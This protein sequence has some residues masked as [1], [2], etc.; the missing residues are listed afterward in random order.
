MKQIVA[1]LLVAGSFSVAFGQ[2]GGDAPT[3]IEGNEEALLSAELIGAVNAGTLTMGSDAA[4]GGATAAD[5]APIALESAFT[6]AATLGDGYVSTFVSTAGDEPVFVGMVF[7]G[8]MLAGLPRGVSDGRYDIT[9]AAGYAVWSCCGHEIVVELPELATRTTAFEHFVLNWNPAGHVPDG[10]YRAP[11][12]DLHFYTVTNEER[13]DIASPSAEAMCEVPGPDGQP[14]RAPLD[15]PS[16]E[17]AMTPLPA[18]MMPPGYAF[19]GAVEPGMGNHLVDLGAPEFTPEG[20][21]KT[22]IYGTNGGA[23]TFWEPMITLDYFESQPSEC[24]EISLPQAAPEAG[25]YPSRYCVRYLGDLD[26]YAVTL[27]GFGYLPQSAS[28]AE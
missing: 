9:D 10:V 20:F 2:V 5:L 19:V 13:L 8:D 6:P 4:V 21:S 12:F 17:R 24:S 28:A 7:P 11:H 26:L 1:A 16:F 15:C 3:G 25:F 18:D 27:E 22:W 14:L 23:I